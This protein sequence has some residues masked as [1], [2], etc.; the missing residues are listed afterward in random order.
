MFGQASNFQGEGAIRSEMTYD[1]FDLEIFND[2]LTNVSTLVIHFLCL[3]REVQLVREIDEFEVRML[4]ARPWMYVIIF[5]SEIG[6]VTPLIFTFFLH[7]TTLYT[8]T[9]RS[10]Y[11][12]LY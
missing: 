5:I 1:N 7:E 8:K 6:E 10:M 3:I 11:L 12:I 9:H 4:F 2:E